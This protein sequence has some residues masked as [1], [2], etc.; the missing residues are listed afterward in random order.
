M[1]FVDELKGSNTTLGCRVTFRADPNNPIQLSMA[2]IDSPVYNNYP[3]L[4]S[5]PSIKESI[6]I[7]TKKYSISSVKL[8]IFNKKV[9]T[10]TMFSDLLDT[11]SFRINQ[12]VEI[13]YF[14]NNKVGTGDSYLAYIGKIKYTT[15]DQNTVTIE[16]EDISQQLLS[17]KIPKMY[18]PTDDLILEKSRNIPYPMIYGTVPKSPIVYLSNRDGFNDSYT[19][20]SAFYM[21]NPSSTLKSNNFSKIFR[22]NNGNNVYFSS[23]IFV[24]QDG[25]YMDISRYSI[26]G[27]SYPF[28]NN[29]PPSN[30]DNDNFIISSPNSSFINLNSLSY[31]EQDEVVGYTNSYQSND[32]KNKILR[33]LLKR[34]PINLDFFSH[35]GSDLD[36]YNSSWAILNDNVDAITVESDDLVYQDNNYL[37]NVNEELP[38]IINNSKTIALCSRNGTDLSS[39]QNI[40]YIT[41]DPL[42]NDAES[43]AF[44]MTYNDSVFDFP[45]ETFLI[46]A[47]RLKNIEGVEGELTVNRVYLTLSLKNALEPTENYDYDEGDVVRL[48]NEP[49]LWD[50]S[51]EISSILQKGKSFIFLKNNQSTIWNSDGQSNWYDY[52]GEDND[53]SSSL[54]N[55]WSNVNSFNEVGV[56][57]PRLNSVRSIE[58][59]PQFTGFDFFKMNGFKIFQNAIIRN[60]WDKEYYADINGRINSYISEYSPSTK[61]IYDIISTE[62]QVDSL[63]A[64]SNISNFDTTKKFAFTQNKSIDTKKLI[65]ELSSFS[66]IFPIFKNNK[67]SFINI[68]ESY[69]S[70]QYNH[71]IQSEDIFSYSFSRTD[72]REIFSSLKFNYYYDFSNENYTKSIT[73]NAET[74]LNGDRN[75]QGYS[76]N[77]YNTSNLEKT[78]DCRFIYD[79]ATA[80]SVAKYILLN[81]CNPHNTIQLTLPLSYINIE[82]GDIVKFDKLINDLKI[83]GEDY[84]QFI[85]PINGQQ[86]YNLFLVESV[87]KRQKNIKLK[88]YQLHNLKPEPQEPPEEIRFCP[89]PSDNNFDQ[90]S[91]NIFY[92]PSID[93]GYDSVNNILYIPDNSQCELGGDPVFTGC[94][95]PN[96]VNYNSEANVDDGTCIFVTD[97]PKI[98]SLISDDVLSFTFQ[99]NV[100]DFISFIPSELNENTLNYDV[101]MNAESNYETIYPRMRMKLKLPHLWD[102]N[103]NFIQV[104]NDRKFE[105]VGFNLNTLGRTYNAEF[106]IDDIIGLEP[107][108]FSTNPSIDPYD[109]FSKKLVED[110]TIDGGLEEVSYNVSI[111]SSSFSLDYYLNIS[112]PILNAN[113]FVNENNAPNP[114]SGDFAVPHIRYGYTTPAIFEDQFYD[115]IITL[116]ANSPIHGAYN[117]LNIVEN[118]EEINLFPVNTR[119]IEN[120]ISS[121][122]NIIYQFKNLNGHSDS[123]TNFDQINLFTESNGDFLSL[124]DFYRVNTDPTISGQNAFNALTEVG[125]DLNTFFQSNLNDAERRTNYYISIGS[126]DESFG[127]NRLVKNKEATFTFKIS[128]KFDYIFNDYNNLYEG[129]PPLSNGA[130]HSLIRTPTVNFAISNDPIIQQ[131]FAQ[132]NF[133]NNAINQLKDYSG[134]SS[135]SLLET[136]MINISIVK[137]NSNSSPSFTSRLEQEEVIPS[138]IVNDGSYT[139][140]TDVGIERERHRISLKDLSNLFQSDINEDFKKE[141][142]IKFT[143]DTVTDPNLSDYYFVKIERDSI[144]KNFISTFSGVDTSYTLYS[145]SLINVTSQGLDQTYYRFSIING[146]YAL[147]FTTT[148]GEDSIFDN[149]FDTYFVTNLHT[150]RLHSGSK[151]EQNRTFTEPVEIVP[152]DVI[153]VTNKIMFFVVNDLNISS[154]INE[155]Q[156][157]AFFLGN[158]QLN[159]SEV[160]IDISL[161]DSIAYYGIA[162]TYGKLLN[163]KIQ[164]DNYAFPDEGETD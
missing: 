115:E 162:T 18:T 159:N 120:N 107:N 52:N 119:T 153:T 41:Y 29:E 99:G 143:P 58:N 125:N 57:S 45:C 64:L 75:D 22:I 108:L 26:N 152:A 147:N 36:N 145:S 10:N 129:M 42:V 16:L 123:S 116:Y 105:R 54:S 12:D 68:E 4:K 47:M 149:Q 131:F 46:G 126:T 122:F 102:E 146:N 50:E 71:I 62:L 109:P 106:T 24:G 7:E 63:D 14:A 144:K 127:D 2:D 43:H 134:A 97:E 76:N 25:Q 23:K 17:T 33:G 124:H 95:N 69:E 73:I 100:Q 154:S 60:F 27:S 118:N 92:D 81:N 87:E 139:Q 128:E 51:L 91:Y 130:S 38:D 66:N 21:D 34:R 44:K 79:D 90:E 19:T 8:S 113:D 141:I 49:S 111:T 55:N 156:I 77:F 74:I 142:S 140:Y 133:M 160:A 3:F 114:T 48:G 39:R 31:S 112:I 28:S 138:T 20:N 9:H 157:E 13:R 150:F 117:I 89:E 30:I 83:Y 35:K 158:G 78:L 163:I 161:F 148:G 56:I 164:D 85:Y 61:I 88:L 80:E 15:H 110:I 72:V 96:A 65:E 84:T 155:N 5:F 53:Q 151:L 37:K 98:G 82:L 93:G 94:T 137:S 59:N 132:G 101:S 121:F 6:N 32:V 70:N 135:T 40:T 1:A 104:L 86:K 67:L 11:E 136:V 103:N